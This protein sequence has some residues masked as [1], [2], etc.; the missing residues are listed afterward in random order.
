MARAATAE[1]AAGARISTSSSP[2]RDAAGQIAF[3]KQAQPLE[4]TENPV[5]VLHAGDASWLPTP[6]HTVARCRRSRLWRANRGV[7]PRAGAPLP[8]NKSDPASPPHLRHFVCRS[9]VPP[10]ST[11]RAGSLAPKRLLSLPAARASRAC[12]SRSP[13]PARTCRMHSRTP[14]SCAFLRQTHSPVWPPHGASQ[15]A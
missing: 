7:T 8:A 6:A 10:R 13:V 5:P 11:A 2:C 9:A 15:P 3:Q 14:A 12:F 1:H 4:R